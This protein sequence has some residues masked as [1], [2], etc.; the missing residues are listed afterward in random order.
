MSLCLLAPLL[1]NGLVQL[2]IHSNLNVCEKMQN[3]TNT[4]CRKSNR[5]VALT[6]L[7]G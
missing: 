3:E 1:Q 4:Q 2:F 5:V 6:P 7:I